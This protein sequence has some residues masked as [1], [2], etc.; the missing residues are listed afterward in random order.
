M[1]AKACGDPA[2][3]LPG[4]HSLWD[5]GESVP[6]VELG[7]YLENERRALKPLSDGA[8]QALL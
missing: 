5:Q 6:P 4:H 8:V 2:L 3:D 1:T 7:S